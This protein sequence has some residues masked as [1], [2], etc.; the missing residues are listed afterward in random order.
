MCR[1]NLKYY[2]QIFLFSKVHFF[3]SNKKLL[4]ENL[5]FINTDPDPESIQI[6]CETMRKEIQYH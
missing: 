4:M 1:Y 6:D 3:V 2:E 5:S